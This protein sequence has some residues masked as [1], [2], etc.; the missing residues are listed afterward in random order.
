[1]TSCNHF[2]SFK[3]FIVDDLSSDDD[4][5]VEKKP[6]VPKGNFYDMIFLSF[7]FYSN[8]DRLVQLNA[9][10]LLKANW[11]LLSP[12]WRIGST[13]PCS[14]VTQMMTVTSWS[15]AHGGLGTA[16]HPHRKRMLRLKRTNHEMPRAFPLLLFLTTHPSPLQLHPHTVDGLRT[17]A[18]QMKSFSPYWTASGKA[19]S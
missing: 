19:R 18:A 3:H 13:P 7:L 8:E 15:K 14:S 17:R 12:V 1:M 5:I 9:V 4:F 2:H 16:A 6:P 10:L 11:R